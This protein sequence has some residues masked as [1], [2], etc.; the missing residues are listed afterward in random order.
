MRLYKPLL[1]FGMALAL[2][3][4]EAH[5][6]FRDYNGCISIAYKGSPGAEFYKVFVRKVG[7]EERKEAARQ[8]AGVKS[9]ELYGLELD[10]PHEIQIIPCWQ[11]P[12]G[13]ACGP[14]DVFHV[15]AKMPK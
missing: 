2:M 10:A 11:G 14:P 8:P 9:V 15:W 7:S 4:S 12:E 5:A 6:Q 13:E 3:A 1:P